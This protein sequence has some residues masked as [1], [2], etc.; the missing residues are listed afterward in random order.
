MRE[1]GVGFNMK[2]AERLLG[3]FQRFHTDSKFEGTG[4][5]LATLHRLVQK[6]VE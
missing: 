1:D 4:E 3:V 6:H 2:Y 5:I